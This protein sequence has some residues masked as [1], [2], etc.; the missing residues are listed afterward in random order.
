MA[1]SMKFISKIHRVKRK[2]GGNR[3][4][5]EMC[6][7]N[8]LLNLLNVQCLVSKFVNKLH[9][10]ETK[11]IFHSHDIIIFTETWTNAQSD[12]VVNGFAHYVLHRVPKKRLVG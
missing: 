1:V 12:M 3:K 10:S 4:V 6:I 8:I 7:L 5:R 9:S 11:A 2:L